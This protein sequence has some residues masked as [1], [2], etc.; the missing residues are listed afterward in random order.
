ML[1]GKIPI[2]DFGLWAGGTSQ[3]RNQ[4]ARDLSNA[5]RHVGFV[6]LVNH[7]IEQNLLTEAFAWSKK[8]FDLPMEKKML[9]P[10][11]PGTGCLVFLQLSD[12]V[13]YLGLKARFYRNGYWT[14]C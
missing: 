11:P 14:R 9:V 10:H 3:E 1:S 8:L 6:Y 7:G 4:I 2:V 5:C 13:V 12:D